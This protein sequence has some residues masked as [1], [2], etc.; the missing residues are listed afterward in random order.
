MIT[1]GKL[2]I[3]TT[4]NTI[5]TIVLATMATGGGQNISLNISIPI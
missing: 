2:M 1:R 3:Q 5:V 4:I